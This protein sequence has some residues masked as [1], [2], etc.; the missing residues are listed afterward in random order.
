M[1]TQ[2]IL[3][4]LPLREMHIYPRIVMPVIVGSKESLECIEAAVVNFDS[5]ILC[6]MTHPDF[7]GSYPSEN[8]LYDIGF[9]C[10]INQLI[11][12]PDQKVRV[13]LRGED[14][15]CAHH[16]YHNNKFIV[17]HGKLVPEITDLTL[18]VQILKEKLIT[19]S[20]N[21]LKL[22]K[23][24]KTEQLNNLLDFK[25]PFDVLY[26]TCMNI[27]LTIP[28]KQ[29]IISIDEFGGKARRMLLYLSEKMEFLKLQ[30]SINNQ[31][32]SKLSKMQRDH[33]LSEQ[34]KTIHKE[35]GLIADGQSELINFKEKI[36]SLPL[37]PEA[38]KKAEEELQKLPRISPHSPEYFVSYNYLT[39]IVDLPW[40]NPKIN[41][42]DI[43]TAEEILNKDH[44]GLEK[45]KERILEYLAVMQFNVESK[46]Q[47]L[48]FVGP[49]GVGKTSLGKSIA[50]A[51]GREFIRL[52]VGGV[53]DEA[54]IRGHRK[55]YIGAM[56]GI[57]IQS[58]KKAGTI[59]TLIM[60]D[61]IDKLCN[62]YKG[63][64]S[65]ALLEVLDPEQN[66]S[67]RDHYL[68][69]GFDLSK[70]FFI[71][72]ANYLSNIPPALKDRMEII[73]LSSYTEYEKCYICQDFIIPKKIIEFATHKRLNIRIGTSII[74]KIIRNYTAEAGV[75]ELERHIN[76][77]FRKSIKK[78][79]RQEIKKSITI[80]D[81]ILKNYLGVPLFTDKDFLRKDTIGLAYGL[82]WTAF[83]GEILLIE[84]TKYDGEGR[85]QMTG[86]IGKVMNESAKAAISLIKKNQ[87]KWGITASVFKK[88]DLHIHIPE[89][90]VPKDGP[91]A[92]LVLAI[93][94]ISVLAE[95]KFKHQ[96]A[97]TGEISLTGKILPIGGLTEKIIAAQRYGFKTVI[98][99]K[100]NHNDL[101]EIKSEAKVGLDFIFAEYIYD[102]VDIVLEK[103]MEKQDEK[104]VK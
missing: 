99:P 90:A 6:L 37:P 13:L 62:D 100:G 104:I 40:K 5:F 36:E 78:Q 25:D 74:K 54:E 45:I 8:D 98:L 33:Y 4:V 1:E 91:S 69:F 96:Y 93:A 64:P 31:V 70:V 26:F 72:T 103:K 61:E 30:K 23:N 102:V 2:R 10:K 17:A 9:I 76:A 49:P 71:T 65:A 68:D 42:V 20:N 60:I 73:R 51:L 59:N 84:V 48:C 11:K 44:Y 101:E 52:S 35:M 94:V 3:P 81:Q 50:K 39:W 32:M 95:R 82:A 88:S 63:D 83:G 87:K 77:I 56:P 15:F 22:L 57:I 79:L 18:E 19:E 28:E 97:M 58:L 89:G 55:T 53:T 85:F 47:I 14:K 75:R 12:M 86:N 92:G 41:P 24:V 66:N 21:Y 67:F 43:E 29:E 7:Q 80:N 34:L 16:L 46:A 27:D 38:K